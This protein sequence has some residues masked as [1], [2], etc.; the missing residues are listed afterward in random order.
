MSKGF[1]MAQRGIEFLL[2]LLFGLGLLLA[3]MTDPAKV[4]AFLDLAGAW[5]PSLAL[6]MGGGIV[7]GLGAFTLAKRRQRTLLGGPMMLPTATA[8]DRRLLGGSAL[9]GVGWGLAGFCPGPAVV[10]LGLGDARVVVFVAAMLVGMAVFEM[11]EAL[12]LKRAWPAPA[13]TPS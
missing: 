12:R 8:M 3:G 7:V 6:V 4:L 13:Q 10:S 5:D 9:F 1:T 2:G 11:L